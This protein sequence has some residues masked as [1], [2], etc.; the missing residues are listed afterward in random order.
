MTTNIN[1]QKYFDWGYKNNVHTTCYRYVNEI[2]V[3]FDRTELNQH[4]PLL[5]QQKKNQIGMNNAIYCKILLSLVFLYARKKSFRNLKFLL[6]P[7]NKW[8]A[9]YKR[10]Y[11]TFWHFIK[12]FNDILLV[13]H[14]SPS[15]LPMKSRKQSAYKI[16]ITNTRANTNQRAEKSK[17][18]LN[19]L[20]IDS[21]HKYELI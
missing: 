17:K 14:T 10:S 19:F 6:S 13:I 3:D 9:K 18:M 4:Y 8:S 21:S 15:N 7:Y 1:K 5:I 2:T 20:M 12:F 11:E 16:C